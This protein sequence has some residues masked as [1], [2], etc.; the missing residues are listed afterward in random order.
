MKQFH[1]T[2]FQIEV[3]SEEPIVSELPVDKLL[4]YLEYEGTFG[5]HSNLINLTGSS[6]IT[7]DQL[8]EEC[9]RHGTDPSFFIEN[10]LENEDE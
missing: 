1:K 3:L 2:I 10:F 7:S 5:H 4:S 9:A 8:I 6:E